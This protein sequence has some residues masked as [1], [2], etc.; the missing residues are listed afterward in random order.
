[1]RKKSKVVKEEDVLSELGGFEERKDPTDDDDQ[2]NQDVSVEKDEIE[3]VDEDELT[4]ADGEEQSQ[5]K[6]KSNKSVRIKDESR[7]N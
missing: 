1:M 4:I 6:T 3:G 5:Q 7:D 2:E